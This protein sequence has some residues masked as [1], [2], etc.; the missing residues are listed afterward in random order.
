MITSP[1]V[2]AAMSSSIA[3]RR[4]PNPGALTATA[5]NVPR[6][7]FTTRVASASPSTS[8]AI[9]NSGFPCCTTCSST[10]RIS[11]I[12]VIFLSVIK[13]YGFSRTASIL[14]ESV[15][16]YGDAYPRSNCIPST[17]SNSVVKPL[18]SSIVM[19]P[20]LPTRSIASAIS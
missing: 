20:S 4:S 7:L 16:M 10:G 15:T 1:P 2:R 14:S 5:L 13:I 3:L 17:T 11:W 8:S 6:S 18:D 12:F 9:N 19:T